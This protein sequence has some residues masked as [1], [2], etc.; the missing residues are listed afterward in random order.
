MGFHIPRRRLR[1]AGQLPAEPHG[2][3]F[4]LLPHPATGRRG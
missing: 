1:T 4:G 3:G 2:A